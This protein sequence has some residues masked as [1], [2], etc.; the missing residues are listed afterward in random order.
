MQIFI[1]KN[2]QNISACRL[3]N[4]YKKVSTTLPKKF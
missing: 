3:F 1:Q 4:P 2:L